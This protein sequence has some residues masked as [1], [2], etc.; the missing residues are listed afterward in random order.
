MTSTA[1]SVFSIIRLLKHFNQTNA[2][3]FKQLLMKELECINEAQLMC[4]I[5]PTLSNSMT[6][7]SLNT[8]K[9]ETIKLAEQQPSPINQ[10]ISVYKQIQQQYNDGFSNLSSDI[11]DYLGTFLDKKQSIELGYLNKQLYIETQKHSYLLKRNND[12]S[13]SIDD[14]TVDRFFW[15]QTN[16]FAYSLPKTLD[17]NVMAQKKFDYPSLLL[18]SS[19]WYK[20][21]FN[22]LN[23]FSC[24]NFN[25]LASIPIEKFFGKK[26]RY[27]DCEYS[28]RLHQIKKFGCILK[29]NK[30]CSRTYDRES[31]KNSVR[32]FCNTFNNYFTRHCQNKFEN[33]RTIAE[34]IIKEDR[35]LSSPENDGFGSGFVRGFGAFGGG[36]GELKFKTDHGMRKNVLLTLGPISNKITI[37]DTQIHIDD[38]NQMKSIFHPK[39]QVFKFTGE[40]SITFPDTSNIDK[41]EMSALVTDFELSLVVSDAHYNRQCDKIEQFMKQTRMIGLQ[42]KMKCIRLS[43]LGFLNKNRLSQLL[44]GIFNINQ[45]N[46]D[47]GHAATDIENS[48]TSQQLLINTGNAGTNL[49]QFIIALEILCQFRLEILNAFAND[50]NKI[51]FVL[52]P[53]QVTQRPMAGGIKILSYESNTQYHVD[54]KQIE[55]DNC[56]LSEKQLGV[57]YQNIVQWLKMICNTYGDE[58]LHD[59]YYLHLKLKKNV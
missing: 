1:A 53:V 48:C 31:M 51:S 32:I 23:S 19:K 45:R 49:N 44:C 52:C 21:I 24:C 41:D 42:S 17:I 33:I 25:Y 16:P 58:K 46:G 18:Q 47:T 54:K 8:L 27:N 4:Q 13:C 56:D 10:E 6:N 5:L 3:K 7:E 14:Y 12:K 39:L 57:L 34:L 22:V 29:H 59:E 30:K 26:G 2:Q 50:F 37:Q 43:W 38:I 9:N 36:S 15:Q 40:C 55:S 11:I 28:G 20:N 35:S